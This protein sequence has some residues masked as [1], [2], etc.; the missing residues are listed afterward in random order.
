MIINFS[1][2]QKYIY[3]FEN[4]IERQKLLSLS[5]FLP[6]QIIHDSPTVKHYTDW[7]EYDKLN[8]DI[9]PSSITRKELL[10]SDY[11]QIYIQ[12]DS[13]DGIEVFD[14]PS[15]MLIKPEEHKLIAL[16]L[17]L[18]KK[19]KIDVKDSQL[20]KIFIYHTVTEK[21][22]ISPIN[23]EI[24]VNEDATLDMIYLTESQVESS[25][26]SSVISLNIKRGSQTNFTFISN[27][28]YI[29]SYIKAKCEGELN[30]II[31]ATKSKMAHIE[32]TT[33]LGKE[34]RSLFNAK[35]IGAEGNKIDIKVSVQH[36]G[37]KSYS[38][39]YLK[40]IASDKALV[41]VRGDASINEAA[42]DSSTSIIGRAYILG[43][44]AK[45][46]VAPMLEVKT[47]K[48]AMAKHSASVSR[49]PED[50]IFYLQNRGLSRKEAE[51]LL[52]KSF[53]E[54]EKDPQILRNIIEK[55]LTESKIIV[56]V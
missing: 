6:Y 41:V 45:A 18:S 32:Y 37:I 48:V 22:Y 8:L 38:E 15:N 11:K 4:K 52:I 51:A 19:I 47:G 27:T 50:L 10:L 36:E 28:P 3:N 25:L 26:I 24:N 55:I 1:S 46:I 12:N 16:T 53:I 44:E 49:V 5:E 17:A 30:S 14:E 9:Y 56:S 43:K 31:F 2:A 23:I 29:Y 39:G 42:L 20:Q 54:D 33:I 40:S 7:N 34:A 35:A 21:N 13:I